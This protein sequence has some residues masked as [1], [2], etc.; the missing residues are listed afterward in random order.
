MA[1]PFCFYEYTAEAGDNF[2]SIAKMF[3]LDENMLKAFNKGIVLTQGASVKIPAYGGGCTRGAFYAIRPT[4]SL[5]SISRR[6]GI[7]L[8]T[9]LSVNPY[10][11][12]AYCLPGQVIIIPRAGKSLCSYTLGRGERLID[13]L[14]KYDME[15]SMFCALNPE[16]NPMDLHE[17]MRVTV[18]KRISP[19][20]RRYIIRPGESIISVSSRFGM[21]VENLLAA[22]NGLMPAEFLPG[23]VLRI[24]LKPN[25]C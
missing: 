5:Y 18:R 7:L 16:L 12:P 15:L 17:D 10:F 24:P 1:Y 25:R 13:V 20:F 19:L 23:A 8:R 9:L 22:N 2:G 4:D 14:K 11:N 3:S 6:F 21:S